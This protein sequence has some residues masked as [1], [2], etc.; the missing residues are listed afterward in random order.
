LPA[1]AD[2]ANPSCVLS[3]KASAI[4]IF[5][6]LDACNRVRDFQGSALDLLLM[7]S[8]L[9]YLRRNRE[10]TTESVRVIDGF[11]DRQTAA[12]VFESMTKYYT[13]KYG[14]TTERFAKMG[15]EITHEGMLMFTYDKYDI[16][17]A[18]VTLALFQ[19]DYFNDLTDAYNTVVVG[20]DFSTRANNI[21]FIDWSDIKVGTA[22]TKQVTRRSPNPGTDLAAYQC[23]IE[24]TVKTYDLRSKMWTVLLDRP[25]RHLIYHNF[26]DGC[27][28]INFTACTVP[29]S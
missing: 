27:P 12:S 24:P 20:W 16:K 4:G 11:T 23:V 5:N 3:Y 8:D 10:A 26:K 13:A 15:E 29:Q 18:G 1:I 17:E 6:L 19:L 22:K 9:Y 25:A 28:K 7:F 14:W 21:W 2:V